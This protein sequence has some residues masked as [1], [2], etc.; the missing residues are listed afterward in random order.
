MRRRDRVGRLPDSLR[1]ARFSVAAT[2]AIHGFVSGS[3]ATRIPAIKDNLALGEGELGIALTGLAAGLFLGTRLTGRPVGRDGTRLPIRVVLP[4]LCLSLFGPA[5]A[6]D[7]VTLTIAFAFVGLW[8][9]FLDVVMNLNAVVV[10][11]DYRRPIMSSL[12]GMWSGGLLAGSSLGTAAA[13]VRAGVPL[14]FGVAAAVLALAALTLTRGLLATAVQPPGR[15]GERAGRA[16]ELV[17]VLLLGGIAFSSFAAEGSAADWSA[18]YVHETVGAGQGIAGLAFTAF[19]LGMVASRFAGDAASA[20]LGPVRTVRTGGLVAAAG[21]VLALAVPSPATSVVGFLLFGVGLAPIVPIA[22]SAAG[23]V[24]Q[25]GAALSWAVTI[26]YLGA[27]SGP[28]VIGFVADAV[29]LRTA[30]AFP[31]LL[32]LTAAALAFAV[33]RAP[34]GRE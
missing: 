30:L 12:H 32:A 8:S 9:G 19:S 21:L 33:S 6:T 24:G 5:I 10:E 18:V 28:A 23:A 20:R 17:A 14:H 4:L 11:R 34:G 15:S 13:A 2:F 16:V 27:V 29:S 25:N 26:A 3:W 1:R 7:L 22:F 31:V